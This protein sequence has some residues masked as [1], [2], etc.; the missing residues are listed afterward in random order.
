[1]SHR[2]SSCG[3]YAWPGG[4]APTTWAYTPNP[5]TQ[6]IRLWSDSLMAF[7]PG[8]YGPQMYTPCAPYP[9][10]HIDCCSSPCASINLYISSPPELYTSV[11]ISLEPCVAHL[12]LAI[13]EI[14]YPDPNP[15]PIVFTIKPD[16]DCGI[17]ITVTVPE[18]HP[19]GSFTTR[20]RDQWNAKR[21]DLTVTVQEKQRH[22]GRSS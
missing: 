20:I 14:T 22:S 4:Y 6:I 8:A 15:R 12:N 10:A 9:P 16:D 5:L 2:R 3:P 7:V 13:D 11:T 18:G 17:K 1:M 21:G 19:K